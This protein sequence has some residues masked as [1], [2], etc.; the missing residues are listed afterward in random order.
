LKYKEKKFVEKTTKNTLT[1]SKELYNY[2]KQNSFDQV[3]RSLVLGADLNWTD[4]E[5]KNKNCIH[6]AACNTNMMYLDYLLQN[7][8]NLNATDDNKWSALFYAASTNNAAAIELLVKKKGL[9]LH[10]IDKNQNT[11]FIVAIEY[12]CD[13][14]AILLKMLEASEQDFITF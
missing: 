13:D 2:I 3:V 6:I 5:D 8:A 11:P 1:L 14:A 7:G 4:D 10:S 12:K 9:S